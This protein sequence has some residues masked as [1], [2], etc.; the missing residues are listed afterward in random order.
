[1]TRTPEVEFWGDALARWPAHVIGGTALAE[2]DAAYLRETGLPSGVD[3]SLQISAPDT[4]A[5]PR[6]HGGLAS[7]RTTTAPY[8]SAL[9]HP[10]TAVSCGPRKLLAGASSTPT[11]GVSARFSFYTS[12]ID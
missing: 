3:W 5:G 2:E 8:P 1:M 7:S 9:M 11:F 6:V 10:R 4:D 12:A